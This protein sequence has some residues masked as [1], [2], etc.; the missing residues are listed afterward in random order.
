MIRL[1]QKKGWW[2]KTCTIFREPVMILGIQWS[3]ICVRWNV[4]QILEDLNNSMT[5]L[6]KRSIKTSLEMRAWNACPQSASRRIQKDKITAF[7]AYNWPKIGPLSMANAKVQCSKGDQQHRITRGGR[8]FAP[9]RVSKARWQS[10][11]S[12]IKRIRRWRNWK[13]SHKCC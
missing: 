7:I 8:S 5:N 9:Q 3:M 13:C 6:K 2:V 11:E 1:F 4:L 10:L 12:W